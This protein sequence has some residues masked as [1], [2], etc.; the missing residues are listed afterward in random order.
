MKFSLNETKQWMRLG[1][2]AMFGQ[3]MINFARKNKKLIVLSADLGRSSGLARF[4]SEFPNQYLSVG[5]SEQNL[6]GVA[7]GMASEGYKVFVTSFAPFLSMRA[8]E[9]IRMNLGYMK[10]DVNLVALGSGLS[11]GFLGNSHFGLEDIAVMRTI[12][13]LNITCPAD[14]AELGKVLEDYTNNSRGPSYIRLSGLP[15]SKSLYQKNFNYKFGKSVTITKGYD[16]LI[17]SYGSLLGEIKSSVDN[18]KKNFSIELINI[19]TIKPFDNNII[20]RLR[21]FNKIITIEEH[22]AIGGLSS[23]ISEKIAKNRI[24]TNF[25]SISLPDK[26]G[27]TGDYNFLLKYHR[28]NSENISKRILKFL[29]EKKS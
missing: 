7:A 13:N 23:I 5:I 22:S 10:H 20:K 29:K 11:M 16:L 8:S 15:G 9:Q 19:P 2:R 25:L 18:L 24:K 1:P 4:K 14:C 21:A 27:P 26:F 12:P 17:L 6:I 28:L 3:F